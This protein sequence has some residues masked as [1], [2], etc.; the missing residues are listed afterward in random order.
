MIIQE[1]L[2]VPSNDPREELDSILAELC[3]LVLSNQEKDSEYY[4]MVGACV[5]GPEGQKVCRTSYQDNKKYVHAERAAIEAYGDISPECIVVTTLSPCNSPMNDRAGESCEDLIAEYGIEHVYS[6]YKDPTQ[7]GDDSIETRNEKLREL[8]KRLADTFLDEARKKKRKSRGGGYFFP[9]YGYYGGGVGSSEGGDGGGGESKSGMAEGSESYPEILYHGST[10]EING[11]LTPRQ[12]GD[13]GGAKKSNKNA[14]YA[15]DD[16]NFAIAYSLAERGS[17]TGTLGWKKDPHLIFFGG[18]IRHGQ[19][20]YIHILP[21]RD[22]QGRPLFVRGAADAEWY[23]RPGVK[24]VTPTEVKPLPVDQYLHLLR[25]PTPEEQKIFQANKAKA[26]Q[27]VA[28]NFADGRVKGKSRPGRVKRSGASC[29]GS[30]TDLRKRA[31]NAS[32]ERARMYHWCANM[33]S[34]KKK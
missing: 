2:T 12:A 1:I 17:D 9:G 6:G 14:I 15:T 5:L 11:P 8:C 13:I 30:V 3:E 10:Q 26:K 7:G 33:K 31:K 4:G 23:S 22:E 16:P 27:G 32:G 18:K 28:E 20:V 34:G 25:K 21:T 24:E 29:S 19:N